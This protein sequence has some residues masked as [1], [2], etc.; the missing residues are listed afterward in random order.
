[1]PTI[2]PGQGGQ[3][4][5]MVSLTVVLLANI[6]LVLNSISCGGTGLLPLMLDMVIRFIQ[7]RNVRIDMS[8]IWMGKFHCFSPRAAHALFALVLTEA[9]IERNMCQ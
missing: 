9:C 3:F 4:C 1:M 8:N 5:S 2:R 7:P 6:L